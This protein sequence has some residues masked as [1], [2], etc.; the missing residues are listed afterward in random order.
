M[1]EKTQTEKYPVPSRVSNLFRETLTSPVRGPTRWGAVLA[2]GVALGAALPPYSLYPLA[3]GALVPLLVVWEST[4]EVRDAWMYG[5]TGFLVF[6][7]I[8]GWWGWNHWYL[9][10]A[11]AATAP[12]IGLPA[13]LGLPWA[14]ALGVRRRWGL[15]AGTGTLLAGSLLV[16]WA[17]RVEPLALPWL[18]LGHTQAEAFPFNQL[19]APLG[20]LGLSAWVW[21][22]NLSL[23]AAIRRP[24]VRGT[25]GTDRDRSG[26]IRR[27]L[28]GSGPGIAVF[29]ALLI[30]AGSY[31]SIQ[32]KRYGSRSGP[33]SHGAR[34]GDADPVEADSSRGRLTA[35]IVQPG[36]D[37]PTWTD[38]GSRRAE[39]L[40]H[41]SDSLLRARDRAEALRPE[42]IVWP[43]TA[44]PL[45]SEE[46]RDSIR[47]RLAAWAR[48]RN[49]HLLTGATLP[50]PAAVSSERRAGSGG[51]ARSVDETSTGEPSAGHHNGAL[52]FG[53]RG[54]ID[55]YAK[56]RLVPFAEYVPGSNAW[57]ILDLLA[58]GSDGEVRYRP[59]SGPAVLTGSSLRIGPL[60][61]FESVFGD[62]ARTARR[63]GAQ[64][65]TVLAQS[66][67]WGRTPGYRQ[68]FAFT[69][70]RAIEA[71]LPILMATVNGRSGLIRPTGRTGPTIEWGRRTAV[72]TT[73]EL[74]FR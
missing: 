3:W 74:P 41:L 44:L 59:G 7:L 73:L 65:L 24:S 33:G 10:P 30:A 45:T 62:L 6:Y 15:A 19:A 11:L 46:S 71:R 35:A 31:G 2:A 72:V 1:P 32:M 58:L 29:A 47:S 70:L 54:A 40:L 53:P 60:I 18:L 12:L 36:L 56:R 23:W 26:P 38:R 67:W 64:L 61:C 42:L 52:L 16:E 21:S 68:H 51:A 20:S 49:V 5:A 4:D 17:L 27:L 13:V 43:E 48:D 55:R 57:P 69:R 9:D 34:S 50:A 66:G 37:A 25:S 28:A 63:E 39:L 8:G 14:A 22:L